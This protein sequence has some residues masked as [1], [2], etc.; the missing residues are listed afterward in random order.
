MGVVTKEK[1]TAAVV[2]KPTYESKL[3]PKSIYDKLLVNRSI[4]RVAISKRKFAFAPYEYFSQFQVHS[5]I[6]RQQQI[7]VR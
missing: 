5:T 6:C 2:A 4:H 7:D 3:R 1:T